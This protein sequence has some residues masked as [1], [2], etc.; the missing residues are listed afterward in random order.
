MRRDNQNAVVIE[1]C[2]DCIIKSKVL[3]V[4]VWE[5]AF[6][7][8]FAQDWA[9]YV[10][11]IL[12]RTPRLQGHS[13]QSGP[14][15]IL[16]SLVNSWRVGY[17]GNGLCISINCP[18]ATAQQAQTGRT[19]NATPMDHDADDTAR[20]TLDLLEARL[21]QAEYTI[22][23]HLDGNANSL[24]RKSVAERLHELEK[25]LDLITTKSKVAQDLLKLRK[26]M[27]SR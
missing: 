27:P 19:P 22:Y 11:S 9:K 21:R 6:V 8:F 12:A 23:G 24:K 13:S 14:F 4:L 5:M 3:C 17:R 26:F 20:L 2:N 10:A 7:L 1:E 18:P 15:D 16:L 25:G